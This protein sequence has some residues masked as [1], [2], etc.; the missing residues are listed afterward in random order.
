MAD[1]ARTS[2]TSR[3]KSWLGFNGAQEGAW[4]GPFFGMGESNGWYPLNSLED[5]WQRHLRID[6]TM[7]QYIPAVA[8][9]VHLHGSAGAQMRPSVLKFDEQRNVE[10]NRTHVASRTL[11]NPNPFES[12]SEFQARCF[13]YVVLHGMACVLGLR[14][15]R[16]EV[17]QMYVLEPGTWTL[18]IDP[19]SREP[20]VMVN[21]DGLLGKLED[22]TMI[23]PMRDIFIFKWATSRSNPLLGQSPLEAAGMAGAV[24]TALS[25]SQAAF[26][27]NM[28]RP[29]GALI[30][31]EKLTQDQMRQLRSAFD[32][33]AKSM[34]SGG[35]PILAGGLKWNPM[36]ITSQDAEAI[37]TLKMTT[38]EIARAVG[39]PPPLLGQLDN[40]TLS[41]VEQLVSHWMSISMGGLIEQFERGLDRLFGLDSIN[42]RIEMDITALLRTDFAERMQSYGR[43]I[44]GGVMTPNE[45]RKK[46]GLSPVSGGDDIFL[47]RQMTSVGL[48][49]QLN[50]NE[51]T[52]NAEPPPA[53]P[54]EEDD[55]DTEQV[56]DNEEK[57]LRLEQI[58][59]ALKG[60]M[61]NVADSTA[62]DQV[63]QLQETI[64]EL[65]QKMSALESFDETVT[66]DIVEHY[67]KLSEMV[68]SIQPDVE[69]KDM[70]A[71]RIS[72]LEQILSDIKA[73]VQQ[74]PDTTESDQRMDRVEE[75]L[76]SII[77]KLNAPPAELEIEED[78]ETAERFEKLTDMVASIQKA[79]D[80][81]AADERMD[82]L[83]Q[84]LANIAAKL[85]APAVEPEIYDDETTALIVRDAI[86]KAKGP[87][88]AK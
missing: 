4:R 21:Q 49:A 63:L 60:D 32:E 42:N 19:E 51:L 28:R 37:E 68:A 62:R 31:D 85:E 81:T 7:M 25:R 73:T 13:R 77:D 40:A 1:K 23:V 74:P 79:P 3:V 58:L 87:E 20:F 46:E 34:Q 22:A 78:T 61:L 48:L 14:N 80:T 86:A 36:S 17:A 41:N 15:N 67:Q 55:Q 88:N 47:Q 56:D 39:V 69:D 18:Y 5:G 75:T 27:H 33:Q 84:A 64:G 53:A 76:G 70:S 24:Y 26:F 45:V 9:A 10:I 38:E 57:F 82:R 16:F 65:T 52:N 83:E 8:G 6:H 35:V 50:A 30:T 71:E 72:Q 66:S 12:G 11:V 29:S 59:I 54:P 2:L 43:A 44:Q